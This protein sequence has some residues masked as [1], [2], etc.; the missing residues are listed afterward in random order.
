MKSES[1]HDVAAASLDG[2]GK[3]QKGEAQEETK[4]SSKLT[5]KGV[6]GV[7]QH[8]LAGRYVCCRV[9]DDYVTNTFHFKP[10]RGSNYRV[11]FVVAGQMTTCY[12]Q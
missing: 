5:D 6:K 2:V 10:T 4:G 8:L 12:L 1:S 11:M 9:A 3:A 7:E